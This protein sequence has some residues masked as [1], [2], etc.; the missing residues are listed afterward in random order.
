MSLDLIWQWILQVKY[1]G[2]YLIQM[3]SVMG[4]PV[5]DDTTLVFIGYLVHRRTLDFA[6]TVVAAFLGTISGITVSYW[7]GRTVGHYLIEKYGARLGV[8]PEKVA[9]AHAWFAR[10]GKWSLTIGYFIPG[11]RH[12][13]GFAAGLSKLDYP[14]FALFAYPGGAVWTLT[15]IL[16][17]VMLGEGWS[18]AP[19]QLKD[20]LIPAG[21]A[22]MLAAATVW[23]LR[24]RK[25]NRKAKLIANAEPSE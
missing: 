2:I 14:T 13:N 19:E 3:A 4:F 12:L 6:P 23:W 9:R 8:T 22:L 21:I 20:Y 24:R 5:P 17:G 11:V 18:R 16:T 25:A 15:F 10:V 1:I 7:L